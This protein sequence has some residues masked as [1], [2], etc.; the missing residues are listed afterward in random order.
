[1]FAR[2]R[3]GCC[4]C[5]CVCNT[6]GAAFCFHCWRSM[7][8]IPLMGFGNRCTF[9]CVLLTCCWPL[10]PGSA[11]V[12]R[13]RRLPSPDC[14]PILSPSGPSEAGSLRH[15]AVRCVVC[16]HASELFKRCLHRGAQEW[17]GAMRRRSGRDSQRRLQCRGVRRGGSLQGCHVRASGWLSRCRAVSERCTKRDVPACLFVSVVIV[18][19]VKATACL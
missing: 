9:P 13:L 6:R 2:S 8:C 19:A 17:A 18:S 16:L 3:L 10:H 5:P 15:Q 11:V 14:P 4:R 7:S 1:M 12:S